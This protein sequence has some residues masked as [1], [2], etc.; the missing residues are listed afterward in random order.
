MVNNLLEMSNKLDLL[1]DM[2]AADRN[3]ILGRAPNLLYIH[4]QLHQMEAFRNQ[5]LHQA[6]QASANSRNTLNRLFERLNKVIEE[7]DEY[8]LTLARNVLPLVRA[9]MSDV[10]VRLIKIAEQEEREDEKVSILYL[11]ITADAHD[12]CRR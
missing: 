1:E 10:V 7:F 8:I 3:N 12:L 6:K 4:Y 5:T 11:P 2:L 9:G